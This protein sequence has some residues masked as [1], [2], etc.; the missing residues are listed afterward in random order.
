LGDARD[1]SLDSRRFGPV[2][3]E[4]LCG[5]AVGRLWPPKTL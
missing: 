3:A 5:I 2:P 4:N 1:D